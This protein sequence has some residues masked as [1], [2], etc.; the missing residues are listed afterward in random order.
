MRPR[1][2][3]GAQQRRVS[4]VVILEAMLSKRGCIT[5]GRVLRS[6]DPELDLE[7]LRTVM[8]WEYAPARLKGEPVD[9]LMTV[10][11]NFT[12]N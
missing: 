3:T 5:T 10:T 11:V 1:Y 12:L 9:L 8:Q 2:P 6:V 4:G 7:A